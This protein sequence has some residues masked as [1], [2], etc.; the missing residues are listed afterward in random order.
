VI[1][2]KLKNLYGE[3]EYNTLFTKDNKEL[4]TLLIKGRYDMFKEINDLICKQP[5]KSESNKQYK[6]F[7]EILYKYSVKNKL[8]STPPVVS[9]N[10]QFAR[11]SPPF[12]FDCTNNSTTKSIFNFEKN[13]EFTHNNLVFM[14]DST[15]YLPKFYLNPGLHD[16]FI[17]N[18]NHGFIPFYLFDKVDDY[19]N[20]DS[21]KFYKVAYETIIKPE[22]KFKVTNVEYKPIA[23]YKLK[24]E[25]VKLIKDGD[26][27]KKYWRRYITI[28]PVIESNG[29]DDGASIYHCLLDDSS[30]TIF[31][32]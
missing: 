29:N 25:D 16:C 23:V 21:F 26:N 5:S 18:M 27:K 13:H 3:D 8:A 14:S 6:E 9:D 30:I 15:T 4:N 19:I 10:K 20:K 24:D 12:E 11:C 32:G 17:I 31:Y 2:E 22:T 28:T 7:L 1:I